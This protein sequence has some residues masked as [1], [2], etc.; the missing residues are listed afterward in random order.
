MMDSIRRFEYWLKAG[1]FI[2][3]ALLL[4]LLNLLVYFWWK[5]PVVL[6]SPVAINSAVIEGLRKEKAHVQAILDGGCDSPEMGQY[7][8]GEIGPLDPQTGLRG[9]KNSDPKGN[10]TP[11]S[12]SDIVNILEQSTVRVL[13]PVD[14][15][16]MTG[17][18]FFI[19]KDLIVTNRHVIADGDPNKIFITSQ[20]LGGKPIQVKI[21][22]K[23]PDNEIG[24]PDFALLQVTNLPKSI[25]TL[26]VGDDP[27]VL[28][29]VYAAGFPG[30]VVQSD[31]N[32]VTPNTVYSHGEVSVVQKQD[33]GLNLVIHTANISRGNSGGPLVNTCG[34][35]VGVNTFIAPPDGVDSRTLYSLSGSNLRQFLDA[36][37]AQYTKSSSQCGKPAST[38]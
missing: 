36:N 19:S 1:R 30:I 21:L 15:G 35:V 5:R 38:Q 32:D 4:V 8:R 18:G 2:P 11:K 34:T 3:L 33:S 29:N 27:P 13:A 22:A 20:Y 17:S 37:Q 12:Q 7:R 10:E 25:K 24:H 26:S 23:T 14:K 6:D 16:A 31:A 28:Q 9:D